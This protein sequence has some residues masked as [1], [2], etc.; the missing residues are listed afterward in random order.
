MLQ[1]TRQLSMRCIQHVLKQSQPICYIRNRH[2]AEGNIA[3]PRKPPPAHIDMP[4]NTAD[5]PFDFTSD[6]YS[7]IGEI[8]KK[9]PL[10]YKQSGCIPLLWIAQEHCGNWV[11]LSAMNRI[12]EILEIHPMRVY[13][14][15]T[16][17]TMF[18]RSKVGKYHLQVCGTTP[19]MVRGSD[20]VFKAIKDHV[21]IVQGQTSQNKMFT[22]DEV[23]CLAACCNAPMMQVNN[24][25][26]YEDLNY[27]NTIQLLKNLENGCAKVGSQMGRNVA[28]GIQGRTTLKNG[29]PPPECRDFEQ[30]KR[31]IEQKKADK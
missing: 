28:E 11:P 17:Y 20:D 8:L 30:L 18:N 26:V 10:N 29:P 5:T 22:F 24:A 21:G 2:F 4:D 6:E 13:E 14:V 25:E 3:H 31:E 19:C 1:R 23:E 16:F 7:K 12:A 15:A 27:D 9:Y